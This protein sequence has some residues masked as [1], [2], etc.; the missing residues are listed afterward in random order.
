MSDKKRLI[1]EYEK[2]IPIL[3]EGSKKVR[4]AEANDQA[5]E[6]KEM[7]K[8]EITFAKNG[9]WSL[10]K[11]GYGPKGSDLYDPAANQKRKA[12]NTGDQVEGNGQNRNVKSYTSAKQ[13]T[14][15][16]Q[17]NAIAAKQKELNV[18]QPIKTEIPADL[19]AKLEAEANKK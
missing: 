1:A 9:Q 7:K 19:K 10:S 16:V 6:L 2:L 12:N 17:A 11:S 8:E 15:K 4:E 14:A 3:R 18:K 5:Q 13:G